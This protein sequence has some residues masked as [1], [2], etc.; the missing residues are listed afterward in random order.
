MNLRQK[1]TLSLLLTIVL[2]RVAFAQV[3]DIPD[4]NLRAAILEALGIADRPDVEL[5]QALM[6]Q[7][8]TNLRA[9]FREITDLEGLQY[10]TNITELALDN[11]DIIDL[12]PIATLT[13]LTFLRLHHNRI[14]DVTPLAN[15][16]T[17]N[18]LLLANNNIADVAPLA[19]LANLTRLELQNNR[20]TDITS[21]ENLA[22]LDYL[23]TQNNPIF[24]PASPVVNIPDSNLRDAIRDAL[25]ITDLP[26]IKLNQSILRRHLQGL[27][28]G[29]K[30]IS[31]LTGLEYATS[32]TFLALHHN[33]I[34]DLRALTPLVNLTFIRLHDNQINDLRPLANFT[35]LTTLLLDRNNITDIDP[36]A[37]LKQLT[38]LVLDNNNI[39]DIG[40]LANL[41]QLTTLLLVDNRITN[42]S[43]LSNLTNL[44]RLE[45]QRNSITDHG[46]L[47]ALS[48]A[49]FEFDAICNLPPLPIQER[50]HNR[51]RP[52]IFAAW[53]GIEERPD[54][55]MF[56]NLAHHDLWFNTPAMFGLGF[57]DIGREAHIVGDI[58][59]A[60]QV[61]AEF[62]ARNTNM[63]FLVEI[64][65]KTY[66][67]TWFP[68]DWPHWIR[69]A[70]GNRI[71][72][73]GRAQVD[74]V[75]PEVQE[76]II[77]R[78]LAVEKCGLYDGVFFDH[79]REDI[80]Y[81][82]GHRSHEE[83]RQAMV[84]ILQRIRSASRPEF[85]IITNTNDTTIPLTAPYINGGFM[86][87]G[88]P[89]GTY[90]EA[91]MHGIDTNAAIKNSL[92]QVQHVLSWHERHMREPRVN[93]FESR[94]FLD[95]SPDSQL[96]LRWMRAMT[97]MSLTHSDGYMLFSRPGS[98]HHYWYDFWDADLGQ[99]V[100][101][102][103]LL[104]Q[105]TEGLYIREFTNG[106]AV[107]NHSGAPQ[108]IALP[109]E[110]QGVASGH[111]GTEHTLANLD[112]E[113]Y[114][115]MKPKN[116]ADVNGDGVVNILD[117]VAVAQAF[118]KDG[119][120]GDVNG[121]G[122]VNVFDLVQVAGAIGGG[123]AAPSADSLDLS[124]ISAA[125]V[126]RWLALAQ[127][128]GVGDANFQRGIRFLEQLFMALTP[129]ETMLLPNYPNPF[130]PETWIPYRLA[131]E[132]EVAIT[133]YDTKGTLLRR[134]ALGD[135]AAGY[136]AERGK[137]AYWDGRNEGGEAVASGIYIYQF[138]AGDYAA[139]R[140]MV[141]VK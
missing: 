141:I 38:T 7:G 37:N 55:S 44:G 92:A 105:E 49:I 124:I 22:N 21:L 114:L 107:Y 81:L 110:T 3:V 123:G 133:I 100:G 14:V 101:E 59:N 45:L 43:P 65:V 48:P 30:E 61:R 6:H 122:V 86:E 9:P 132:A 111:S 20:I 119:L 75:H 5:T 63:L 28:A 139:S 13:R 97:T 2:G 25:N 136:Y 35:K 51:S 42:V 83:A 53:G 112:G 89:G 47:D 39:T 68:E 60:T 52:S 54:L 82:Q 87:T 46:P 128:L 102:K 130:N 91:A 12:H 66:P 34:S 80:W 1:F 113:M 62:I 127:G 138:R 77:Q 140:R 117:L 98:H 129:K 108:D 84:N 11:N 4:P 24:D 16:I 104:Y 50:I 93:C 8:L 74:F 94:Y 106:W 103:G 88:V 137:A 99:P 78:T 90:I 109:E 67:I 126:E 72:G 58:S 33:E 95:K 19:N 26:E 32:L 15:L 10:A 96:N 40:P 29:H 118:G 131:R 71:I 69:D 23:D 73:D 135:Q 36:L 41:T 85:L 115:R 120:Q 31:D 76:H 56:D 64:R 116:P 121:D 17:L 125:D 57:R 27:D 79:G 134:L 70:Q 18:T